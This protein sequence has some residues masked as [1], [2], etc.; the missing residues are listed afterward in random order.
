MK[1]ARWAARRAR[2]G[3]Q[4]R[5]AT[6]DAELRPSAH[7]ERCSRRSN[8][9]RN[10]R[11][12]M[13]PV[14]FDFIRV[15]SLA[16]L[17][18]FKREG[19]QQPS[20]RRTVARTDAQS[21]SRA[22][23]LLIDI[24]GTPELTQGSRRMMPSRSGPA[25]RPRTSRTDGFPNPVST[26]C[27]GRCQI[28]YRA[29]RNRGTI[30]GSLCHAD[31]AA[32]WVSMLCAFGAEC[33]IGGQG[34]R[35]LP[36]DRFMVGP[37][38]NALGP[39]EMLEAIR[40]H[41]CRLAPLGLLQGLPQGGRIP[42]AIAA[43]VNDPARNRFRAV[44]GA[45]ARPM[46]VGDSCELQGANKTIDEATTACSTAWHHGP[47]RA[48]RWPRFA[49]YEQTKSEGQC[50]SLTMNGRAATQRWNREPIWRISFARNSILLPRTC[51][52]SRARAARAPS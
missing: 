1:A 11:S 34:N 8:G 23:S 15:E 6:L 37:Y 7:P 22:P 51:A 33:L 41:D 30:G 14:A 46:L 39:D 50:R 24:T 40:S 27:R 45:A 16:G 10:R 19:A 52:A 28:A 26:S 3:G 18:A 31:P 4:R 2:V 48:I 38:Q 44:I 42:L 29:V 32:D 5:A 47:V 13:K 9:R 25:S 20:R 49:R 17:L 21:A 43:V 35:R 12:A 36:A